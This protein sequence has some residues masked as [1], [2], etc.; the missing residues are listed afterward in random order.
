MFIYDFGPQRFDGCL[1]C[2]VWPWSDEP[3]CTMNCGGVATDGD[4][5]G[6]EPTQ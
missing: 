2:T 3:R 5:E 1:D 6:A 4:Q